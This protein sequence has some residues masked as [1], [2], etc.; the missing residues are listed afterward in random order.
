MYF[1]FEKINN[2]VIIL[3]KKYWHNQKSDQLK[4]HY[5]K[6]LQNYNIHSD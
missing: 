2:L 1:V 6:S 3:L 5:F 4:F